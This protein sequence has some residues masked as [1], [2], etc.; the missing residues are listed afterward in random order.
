MWGR[1]F[2]IGLAFF[3]ASLLMLLN[4][5]LAPVV[6]GLLLS[7]T[8][9]LLGAKVEATSREQGNR[10]ERFADESRTFSAAG[11]LTLALR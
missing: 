8:L 4:L 5:L 1:L 3:L 10:L 7:G 2:L 9:I 6:L 11:G